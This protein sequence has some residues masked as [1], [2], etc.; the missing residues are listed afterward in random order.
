MVDATKKKDDRENKLSS[1]DNFIPEINFYFFLE[2][3]RQKRGHY[4]LNL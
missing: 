4:K 3:L 2:K 1:Y